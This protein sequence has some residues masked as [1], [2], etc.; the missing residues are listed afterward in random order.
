MI[1]RGDF[2]NNFRTEHENFIS[3]YKYFKV[4]LKNIMIDMEDNYLSNKTMNQLEKLK[5]NYIDKVETIEQFLRGL[6]ALEKEI[7]TL[8][9]FEKKNTKFIC[10]TLNLNTRTIESKITSIK[11]KLKDAFILKNCKERSININDI[12]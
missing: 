9:Y 3:N 10:I 1:I 4:K 12:E 2:M 8:K 6:T 7:V 5:L 11:R